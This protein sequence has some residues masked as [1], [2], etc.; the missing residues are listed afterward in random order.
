MMSQIVDL[1][2]EHITLRWLQLEAM[3]SEA[4]EDHSHSVQMLLRHLRENCHIIQIDEAI[5][6]VQFTQTVLHESLESRWGITQP[7]RHTSV[8]YT[9]L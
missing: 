8:S 7:K 9:H 5:G 1:L 2:L 6:E 3:F 4:I